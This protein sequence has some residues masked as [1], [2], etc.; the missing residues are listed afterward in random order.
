M[1][2]LEKIKPFT[3]L[4][5]TASVAVCVG[6]SLDGYIAPVFEPVE[7]MAEEEIEETEEEKV[8]G[9]FDLED[10]IYEGTGTGFKGQIKV[11]VEI[12]N[13]TIVA[14]E[15]VDSGADDAAFVNRA[16]GVIDRI[17]SSQS[18]DV[19]VVSGATYSSNGIIA[20]V[21][22]ALTGE[23]DTNTVA[24]VSSGQGSTTVAAVEDAAAYK[25][26][27]YYGSGTGFGGTTKVKVV[28]SGGKITSITIE[29]TND[30]S[31]YIQKASGLISQIIAGQTT[32]VDTVS[33]ATYSSVGII[34]AVR[35]ALSQAA[36]NPTENAGSGST[37]TGDSDKDEEAVI[38][39]GLFPYVDGT[40]YGTGEG[41]GGTTNVK[42][43]IGGKTI[44]S[45]SIVSH[46]DDAAFMSRAEKIVDKVV[47]N[48]TTEVDVV[49]GATYSSNGILEAIKNAL[50]E[51]E[52]ATNGGAEETP[53]EDK[54]LNENPNGDPDDTENSGDNSQGPSDSENDSSES[55]SYQE[56]TY[57][58]TVMCEPDEYE[59]FDAYNLSMK[60]TVKDNKI[61]AIEDVVGDGDEENDRYIEWAVNG[62]S[63]CAGVVTQILEKGTVEEI[64]TVSRATCSSN[65][66]VAACNQVLEDAKIVV[67]PVYNDGEYT[68][69]VVCEPDEYEDF[70]AYNLSVT[71]KVENDKIVAITDVGGD[72]D[73]GNDRY[74]DWA[75]NGRGTYAGVV[76]QILEKGTVEEIDIVTRATCSS[77]SI[78]EA[79]QI[80][81]EK[82]IIKAEIVTEEVAGEVE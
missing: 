67:E 68:A 55:V 57:E 29:S 9:N 56:G 81:L 5:A 49:S 50:A 38:I 66:I 14:I 28:I 64:D 12:K 8:Q 32:N 40:Y 30:D 7:V 20:A 82:A 23:V 73:S 31:S 15:I 13:K 37:N 70:N 35:N 47:E 39:E 59:D 79:C 61:V 72:G 62:R 63:T 65:A 26:G 51:A 48:Q 80:A 33:G 52:K 54:D 34:E 22:N 69:T 3:P 58:V 11:A 17:I 43:V 76:T 27:T 45:I 2:I 60:V 71:V 25:D 53:D 24:A 6:I 75:V 44:R 74:I 18:F 21:K 36:V 16:K 42:V 41:F 10:G 4:L 46:E 1:K 77:K 19:D 78:I